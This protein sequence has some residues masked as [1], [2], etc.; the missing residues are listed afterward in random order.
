MGDEAEYK[1][2]RFYTEPPRERRGQK[3]LL[4]QPRPAI[5]QQLRPYTPIHLLSGRPSSNCPFIKVYSYSGGY[6]AHCT[7]LNRLLTKS[8][9]E[10]CINHW[11]TC[12]LYRMASRRRQED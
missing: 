4:E 9:V 8:E 3:G 6:L 7:V 10:L 1:S 5:V 2:C 12:P 11:Q